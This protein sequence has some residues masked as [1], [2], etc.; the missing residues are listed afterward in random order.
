MSQKNKALIITDKKWGSG[1]KWFAF[2]LAKA[3]RNKGWTVY[4]ITAKEGNPRESAIEG[5]YPLWDNID[6]RTESP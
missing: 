1:E 5:N 3:L 2:K 6:P 4:F